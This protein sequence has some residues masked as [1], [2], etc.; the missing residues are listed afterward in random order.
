MFLVCS[1]AIADRRLSCGAELPPGL[2]GEALAAAAPDTNAGHAIDELIEQHRRSR[3]GT[4]GRMADVL[5]H[6]AC[7]MLA[8]DSEFF[9]PYFSPVRRKLKDGDE[10]TAYDKW[11]ES[12]RG[13]EEGDELV[14][15]A[16]SRLLGMAIQ[17]VQ[18]SGYRVPLMDPTGVADG[19]YVSFWGNDDKHWVWLRVLGPAPVGADAVVIAPAA[20]GADA[21]META[22]AVAGGTDAAVDAAPVAADTADHRPAAATAGD[23]PPAA[24][25]GAGP[26]TA[27]VAVGPVDA[28]GTG[29]MKYPLDLF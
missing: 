14:M 3:S 13:C 26:A 8:S 9:R 7:E 21:G 23:A 1:A 24:R 11:V 17:P 18:Q 29:A 22:P 19:G 5:R 27:A 4:L 2:L 6:A 25:A 15:L 10:A 20:T 12:L 16:V 28:S